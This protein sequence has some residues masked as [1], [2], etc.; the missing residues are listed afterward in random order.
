MDYLKWGYHRIGGISPEVA[1]GDPLENAKRIALACERAEVAEA[2]VLCFPELSLTGYTC[3]DMFLRSSL[4]EAAREA[5]AQ[6]RKLTQKRAGALV[7]GAPYQTPDGRLW[8]AAFVLHGGEIR[9]AIPKTYLPQYREF[10]ESR[11]F[12]QT[13]AQKGFQVADRELGSFWL[14]TNQIFQMGK[15]TF[16]LEICEDVW[17]PIPPS[18]RH[19]LAGACVILNLSASNDL[20]GKRVYRSELIRQQSARCLAGYLLVSSGRG[21]STKDCVFSGDVCFA[22]NGTLLSPPQSQVPWEG[23]LLVDCDIDKL[24]YERGVNKTFSQ[25]VHF[26][27]R[28]LADYQTHWLGDA[29][30]LPQLQRVY[31]PNPFFGFSLEDPGSVPPYAPEHAKEVISIQVRGLVER[32]STSGLPRI[33]VGVSGGLD[34]AWALYIVSEALAYLKKPASDCLAFWLPTVATHAESCELAHQLALALRCTWRESDLK[35]SVEAEWKSLEINPS[36]LGVAGENAQSRLRMQRLLNAANQEKGLVIG[37]SD[38][39]EIALGFC[40]YGGD[41][42][43]HYQINASVPKTVIRGLTEWLAET[44]V[45][46]PLRHILRRI[47]ARPYS[48]EL[49]TLDTMEKTEE[50]IG[51]Y[52]VHDFILYHWMRNGFPFEKIKVL[53]SL[54]LKKVATQDQIDFAWNSFQ[55]RFFRNQFK[56]SNLPPGPQVGSVSLSPRGVWR[57]PDHWGPSHEK[58]VRLLPKRK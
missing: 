49:T 8:N 56:R 7:V 25:C 26:E 11:W 4:L 41:H 23:A 42:L 45:H 36:A 53:A 9:G 10:Y 6:L 46:H 1:L 20:V 57:M 34:S 17:A 12:S 38:L 29:L 21:E 48:P 30:P 19:A 31:C 2:S 40:T 58:P 27:K 55:E 33:L 47:L 5:L 3:E 54:S 14:G 16:A 44:H 13:D 39:S 50:A 24:R 32:L 35:E 43:G 51:L 15:L 18:S 22:E 28:A 52:A 37:T